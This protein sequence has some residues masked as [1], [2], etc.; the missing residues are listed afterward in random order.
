MPCPV[1]EGRLGDVI[2]HGYASTT[3]R[4]CFGVVRL[5]SR[6]CGS[7]T[8]VACRNPTVNQPSS[9]SG[10]PKVYVDCYPLEYFVQRIAGNLVEVKFPAPADVDPAFWQPTADQ[11]AE[12]QAADLIL[13][14]GAGYARWV[15]YASLPPS[16]VEV[17]SAAFQSDYLRLPDAVV[18]KHGPQGEH[19]HQGWASHT[20]LD[21]RQ[22]RQQAAA[23][24]DALKRLLPDRQA[25]LQQNWELLDRDLAQWQTALERYATPPK[26]K[27]F[28]SHPVYDYLARFCGW[29]LRS[30]HWE[31]N[32][33]PDEE[34]WN[35]FQ[36]VVKEHPARWMLWEDEPLPRIVDQLARHQVQPI[37]FYV[38]GNRPSSGDFLTVMQQN[39]QRL[40]VLAEESVSGQQVPV[41]SE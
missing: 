39:V 37:V 17:T 1:Q 36:E 20:W 18:H 30:F 31:P 14:N 22:A 11:V 33:M 21:P 23:V 7:L 29:E 27:M 40:S 6:P 19:A 41:D 2:N 5:D 9:V 25:E 32:E 4:F 34:E 15:E 35:R 16:R 13:I 24:R 8:L 26:R 3:D 28:A 10:K 12:Y 38:C